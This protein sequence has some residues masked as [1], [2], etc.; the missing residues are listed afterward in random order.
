MNTTIKEVKCKLPSMNVRATGRT[1][2]IANAII[3]QLFTTGVARIKDHYNSRESTYRLIDIVMRRLVS[4]HGIVMHPNDDGRPFVAQQ[5]ISGMGG[6]MGGQEVSL[7]L[8]MRVPN[9]EK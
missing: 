6:A 3:D 5:I 7:V 1:T 4:E 9:Y 2:R 8:L